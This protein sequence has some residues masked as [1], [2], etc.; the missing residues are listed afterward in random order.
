MGEGMETDHL[1]MPFISSA[2]IA[3]GFH[4]GSDETMCR[5]IDLA[6]QYGVRIGA[7][8]SYPDRENF[9]RRN[10]QLT[11]TAITSL[12]LQQ[13]EIIGHHCERSGARLHHVKP[14]GALYN[15]AAVDRVVSIAIAQAVYSYDPSLI[16]YGLSGSEMIT[17]AKQLGLR[18]ASEVFADRRYT[19]DGQLVPRSSPEALIIDAAEAAGQVMEIIHSGMVTTLSG[20]KIPMLG[21]TICLHGDGEHAVDFARSISTQLTQK[22]I[23]I[24]APYA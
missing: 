10:M 17:A 13:L 22:N 19:D 6:Q 5:T 1:V 7:H 14:H 20:M 11:A 15:Q 18:T 16:F 2:N 3:C 8:P 4:A 9:G 21:E 12:I 24:A 23:S